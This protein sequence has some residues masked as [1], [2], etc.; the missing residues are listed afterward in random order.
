M[1]IKETYKLAYSNVFTTYEP[2]AKYMQSPNICHKLSIGLVSGELA[3]HS[4]ILMFRV[5]KKVTVVAD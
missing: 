4:R 1:V 2:R 3:G 5:V